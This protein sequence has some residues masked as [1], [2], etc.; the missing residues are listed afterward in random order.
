MF[1]IVKHKVAHAIYLLRLET[2]YEPAS[3]LYRQPALREIQQQ[4]ELLEGQIA[5]LQI[6]ASNKAAAAVR[7]V[8]RVPKTGKRR[9][10][11]AQQDYC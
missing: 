3:R 2:Q 7:T 5:G 8:M 10:F 6:Y 9:R 4:R 11:S 1:K